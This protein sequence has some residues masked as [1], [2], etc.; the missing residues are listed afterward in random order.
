MTTAVRELDDETRQAFCEWYVDAMTG[1]GFPAPPEPPP[2]ED[3]YF[4]TSGCSGCASGPGFGGMMPFP[5][6]VGACSANLALSSCTQP[7]S[8]L[9][10]CVRSL[11]SEC[12]PS[13]R[14]CARYL[15][16]T[17]CA[18]TLVVKTSGSGEIDCRIKVR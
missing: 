5:L 10:D 13:P 1:E 3:G 15:E 14:G 12:W 16:S 2:T 6:P 7:L 17:G 4:P 8:E 11:M 9:V 18:G